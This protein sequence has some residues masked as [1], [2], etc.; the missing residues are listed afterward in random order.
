MGAGV[1]PGDSRGENWSISSSL[2][3]GWGGGSELLILIHSNIRYC[4]IVLMILTTVSSISTP[5]TSI[6]GV[7]KNGEN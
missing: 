5:S 7:G 3:I 2:R 6:G 4:A 1:D